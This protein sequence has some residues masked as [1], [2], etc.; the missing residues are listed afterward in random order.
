LIVFELK[1]LC[2]SGLRLT[3]SLELRVED[4]DFGEIRLRDGKG[5]KDRVTMLS[6]VVQAPLRQH[7]QRVRALHE[8]DLA[9]GA[10]RTVLPDALSRKYPNADREWGWQWV[11]PAT[12]RYIENETGMRRRHHLRETVIQRKIK[13]AVRKAGVA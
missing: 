9:Q 12:T 2:G 6:R 8:R 7:L 4:I 1:I 10:G 3:E 5:R 11:F 13:E